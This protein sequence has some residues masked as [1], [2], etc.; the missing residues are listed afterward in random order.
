M[1]AS[2]RIIFLDFF[3]LSLSLD[4]FSISF[5]FLNVRILNLHSRSRSNFPRIFRETSIGM[6]MVRRCLIIQGN[7]Y[8]ERNIFSICQARRQKRR[9]KKYLLDDG[10]NK[11]GLMFYRCSR[12]IKHITKIIYWIRC[13]VRKYNNQA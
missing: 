10:L 13:Y 5:L 1:L 3:S 4:Y 2:I 12:I 7:V 8:T 11:E 9:K 6:V